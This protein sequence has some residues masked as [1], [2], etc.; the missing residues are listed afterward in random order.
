MC[1]TVGVVCCV[2][3]S[4]RLQQRASSLHAERLPR[5]RTRLE[6]TRREADMASGAAD[7]QVGDKIVMSRWGT[8]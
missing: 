4:R 6:T 5:D 7:E 8:R 3:S 1:L 2:C